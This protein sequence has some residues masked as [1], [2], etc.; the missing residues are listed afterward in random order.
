MKVSG[1][2]K[3]KHDVIAKDTYSNDENIGDKIRKII[4]YK[5]H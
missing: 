5:N 2:T 3:K 4:L 1:L